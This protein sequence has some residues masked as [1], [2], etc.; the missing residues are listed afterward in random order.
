MLVKDPAKPKQLLLSFPPRISM[1]R[2]DFLV[3]ASN[4]AAFELI[5]ASPNWSEPIQ[6]ILG[7]AGSGKTHLV[8]IW[9]EANEAFVARDRFLTSDVLLAMENGR[10]VALELGSAACID[11]RAVFHVLNMARQSGSTLLMTARGDWEEW[12]VTVPDVVSRMRAVSPTVLG[13]PDEGL[14]KQVMVKLFA[15][16]QTSVDMVVLEYA[17]LRLERSFEAANLF[18]SAC[19]E[20]ALQS[21]RKITKQVAADAIYAVEELTPEGGC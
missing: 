11:E 13:S 3:G 6:L 7:P 1:G 20:I 8:E 5:K 18:V 12:V 17:L 14:L 21:G 15:D 19:D 9:A 16:R 4:Q 2:D 10:A